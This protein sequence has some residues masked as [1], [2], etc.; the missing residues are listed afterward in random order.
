MQGV[1]TFGGAQNDSLQT[2]Y[3]PNISD[4]F[5][6]THGIHQF[7]FGVQ[8]PNMGRRVLEDETNRQG[9]YTFA[10]QA[11]YLQSTP[12]TFTIQQGQSRFLTYYLQPQAFFQDQIQLTPR[13][14][15][16]SRYPLLLAE[17]SARHHGRHPAPALLRLH[18]G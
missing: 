1:A 3:N 18:V 4:I 11:A 5:T 9:T 13:L 6:W 17:R 2:E 10:S 14:T 15:A 16:S 7:K 8:L 12:S